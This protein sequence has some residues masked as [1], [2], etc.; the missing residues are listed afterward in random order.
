MEDSLES[1]ERKEC[2]DFW[3][4]IIYKDG[5]LN[6]EQVLKELYDYMVAL[7]QVPKVYCAITGGKLSKVNY[8]A[9]VVIAEYERD[10]SDNYIHKDD[11]RDLLK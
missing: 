11:L 3:K 7:Q 8:F 1:I 5:K 10:L 9:D 4:D 6:E 2:L